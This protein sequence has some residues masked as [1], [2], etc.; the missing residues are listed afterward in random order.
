MNQP[1]AFYIKWVATVVTLAGAVF[2]SLGIYPLSAIVLNT[3][4]FLFLIWAVLIR[5][6]AMITVNAGLL[7]IYTGGLLYKLL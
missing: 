5:D 1:I 2:A 6:R 7:S 3:G 4:S